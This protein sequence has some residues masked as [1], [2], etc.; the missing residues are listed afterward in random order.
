MRRAATNVVGL[1]KLF[2]Y[3]LNFCFK[4]ILN[5]ITVCAGCCVYSGVN[6]DVC[7]EQANSYTHLRDY[8]EN[9]NGRKNYSICLLK[10]GGTA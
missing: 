7:S 9:S 4:R 5:S 8:T 6:N 3:F 10:L 2:C 1:C